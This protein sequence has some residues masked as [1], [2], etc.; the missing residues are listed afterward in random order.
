LEQFVVFLSRK[1]LSFRKTKNYLVTPLTLS[2]KLRQGTRAPL[3][4]RR[5]NNKI[6]IFFIDNRPKINLLRFCN[7]HFCSFRGSSD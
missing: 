1:H 2:Q 4:T 6:N 5:S 3:V 7:L